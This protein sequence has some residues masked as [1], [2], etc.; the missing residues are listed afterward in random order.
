MPP[1]GDGP[2]LRTPKLR[3]TSTRR[4]RRII[5]DELVLGARYIRAEIQPRKVL[6][7]G[8]SHIGGL[9]SYGRV[10]PGGDRKGPAPRNTR[11]DHRVGSAKIQA[12]I[13]LPR[14]P[15]GSV[16]YAVITAAGGVVCDAARSFVE[17]PVT[18]QARGGRAGYRVTH[19][20][21][22]RRGSGRVVRSIV[23]DGGQGVGSIARRG[24]VPGDGIGSRRQVRP[25]VD[26]IELKLHVPYR[27]IV[28]GRGGHRDGVRN[29]RIGNGSRDRYARR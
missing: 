21:R 26:S 28:A 3:S 14:R 8:N 15:R 23:G 2:S 11:S 22:D 10:H 6:R 5:D 24:G 13:D 1:A 9:T 12:G 7:L 16:Y 20:H 17:V 29:G 25:Q 19:R 18:N 4:A 27:Y